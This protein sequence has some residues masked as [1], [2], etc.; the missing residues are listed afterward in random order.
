MT[1]T[2]LTKEEQVVVKAF[3]TYGELVMPEWA[4]AELFPRSQIH[5]ILIS[6]YKKGVITKTRPLCLT[7]LGKKLAH[8]Y[9][10]S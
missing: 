10:P 8:F 5:S 9:S 1:F 7:T 6:L 2:T 3:D 4:L